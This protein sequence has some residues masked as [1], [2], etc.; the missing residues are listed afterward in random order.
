LNNKGV[1]FFLLALYCGMPVLSLF[2][3]VDAY[4]LLWIIWLNC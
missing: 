4:I 1:S 2:T 3:A